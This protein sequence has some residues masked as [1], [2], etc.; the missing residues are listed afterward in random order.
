V[1]KLKNNLIICLVFCAVFSLLSTG[2]MQPI[3]IA[4]A[5]E[6]RTNSSLEA[7]LRAG[8]TDITIDIQEISENKYIVTINNRT[9]I[10][11]AIEGGQRLSTLDDNGTIT[12]FE[13]ITS[14][15]PIANTIFGNDKNS[16]SI[17]KVMSINGTETLAIPEDKL[18]SSQPI[19][20]P[21]ELPQTRGIINYWW[22]NRY[23]VEDIA[24]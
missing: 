7:K 11:E 18:G 3:Q 24:T 16:E 5:Q 12:T 13:I 22:D 21:Y 14:R 1:K 6:T 15:R 4:Q 19:D 2:I 20:Y 8:L 23:F 9:I 10:M 17:E